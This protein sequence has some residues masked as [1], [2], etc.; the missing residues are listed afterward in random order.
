MNNPIG[1]DES[2]TAPL[3]TI[4]HTNSPANINNSKILA[5]VV[6]NAAKGSFSVKV[7]SVNELSVGKWVQLRLRSG[8]DELLKKEVGPIYSQMTTEWSARAYWNK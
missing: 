1:T 8:N 2:T 4:K 5:T 6:E 7:G 3:L